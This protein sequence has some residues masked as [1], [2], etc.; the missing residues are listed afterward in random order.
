VHGKTYSPAEG[1]TLPI[2]EHEEDE[3]NA[4]CATGSR[5]E[6]D[7]PDAPVDVES[8]VSSV[9]QRCRRGGQKHRI[10]KRQCSNGR[11]CCNGLGSRGKGNRLISFFSRC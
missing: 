4:T 7:Q 3:Q 2:E 11:H 10:E 5:E 6:V 9:G 1:K 8:A